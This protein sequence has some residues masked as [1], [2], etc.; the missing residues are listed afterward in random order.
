MAEC[1]TGS[2]RRERVV[3]LLRDMVRIRTD[4]SETDLI[5]YLSQ[6]FDRLGI[7][8]SRRAIS[9]GEAGRG[10][11]TA[12][13]G[14]GPRSLVFNSH[15]DTVSPGDP[16]EWTHPPFDAVISGGSLFGRGAADA[17]GPLA[18]MIA[19]LESL[20]LS[21]REPGGSLVLM[22]VGCEESKGRGTA[23][24]VEAGFAADAAVI[25]E[26]TGL[27]VAVSHK[28][29]LRARITVHGRAA[30]A[31]APRSGLNAIAGM[32]PVVSALERLGD[33]LA[34]RQDRLLGKATIAVTE[35]EGG[36]GCNVVPPACSVILDRRLLPGESPKA[37]M[38]EI[39]RTVHGTIGPGSDFRTEVEVISTAE[40]S[41]TPESSPIVTAS[42][43]CRDAELPESGRR[44]A[45]GFP[46]CCD[47][48]H[49]RNRTDVPTV[50]MGP[51][52]LEQAHTVD[53]HI[54]L[55]EL[56]RAAAVYERLA[57]EWL[58]GKWLGSSG[59]Q[60]AGP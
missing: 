9:E 3:A 56:E 32:A 27:D 25:G 39:E 12:R 30:H 34:E 43:R 36:I 50:V 8:Y 16:E 7:P 47:M 6:R 14:E 46:A 55:D 31:S 4:R 26:P 57:R 42:L 54:P 59:D 45:T 29:V 33:R 5:Y 17:K 20:V 11:I 21:G 15:L 28:G 24:E 35:I 18:A 49:I 51:G 2:E 13:W 38:E 48:W 1:R 37:A 60:L 40:A 10:N 53:E 58:A 44:P 23:A 22:A 19:A 41:G 52:S